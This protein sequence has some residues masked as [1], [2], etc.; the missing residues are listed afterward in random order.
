MLT[1]QVED[2]EQINAITKTYQQKKQKQNYGHVWKDGNLILVESFKT[3]ASGKM[4]QA[5]NKLMECLNE[6]GIKVSKHIQCNQM[7]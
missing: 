2:P 3:R 7:Q 6:R 4:C 5:Y 1:T